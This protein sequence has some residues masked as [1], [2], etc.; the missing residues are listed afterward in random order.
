MKMAEIPPTDISHYPHMYSERNE[1]DDEKCPEILDVQLRREYKLKYGEN[2]HQQGAIYTIERIAGKYA[3]M[4]A[5]FTNLVSVRSDGKGKGG[6]SLTNILDVSRAMDALKY[7]QVP[8][9]SVMKHNMASGFAKQTEKSESLTDLWRLARD[10]DRQSNFGCSAVFNV[11]LDI[12]TATAMLEL[13]PGWIIDVV[14]A[15][16]YDQ[17]V[18]GRLEEKKNIRI[19]QFSN[20]D[21]LPKYV[22]DETYNLMSFKE[23]SGGKMGLQDI[24]L[25]KIRSANDLV[26]RPM[27]IKDNRQY[28]MENVPTEGQLDDLLTAWYINLAAARSNGVVFVRNGVSV[29]VGAGKVER[30]GAIKNAIVDGIQK[31]MDREGIKYDPLYGITGME[32]LE[33]NPFV[34]AVCASDG[35]IPFPDNIELLT[36]VGVGSVVQP[37]GSQRDYLII[38]AANQ[39]KIAVVATGERCFGHF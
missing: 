37:Y 17:G 11:P 32:Q 24:Y 22:G 39:K 5:D 30:V 29:S 18:V 35:F 9:V 2:P 23:I 19:A 31:A 28:I 34:G 15:P 33:D 4:M 27:V 38:E 6:L 25:T 14:A 10:A 7:F 13:Y 21:R 3:N 1:P 16:D 12:R 20:L 8:A 26:L 36:R